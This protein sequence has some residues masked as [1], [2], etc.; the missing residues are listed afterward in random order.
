MQ[1]GLLW[2]AGRLA[3]CRRELALAKGMAHD[4]PP[5]LDSHDSAV[6]GLAVRAIG[7]LGQCCPCQERLHELKTDETR[8]R[9]Y[10]A[11]FI[12]IVTVGE[13]A[14]QAIAQMQYSV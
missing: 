13:L 14:V 3:Q 6:C 10:E 1:R 11:G 8:L 9:L 4:L 7:L 5:Y 2:A 12:R